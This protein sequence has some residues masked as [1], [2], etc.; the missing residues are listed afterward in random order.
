MAVLKAEILQLF[1]D[2]FAEAFPSSRN[3]L[4]LANREA[5][6]AE[7]LILPANVRL[8]CLPPYGPALNPMERVWRDLKAALAGFSSPP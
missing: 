2:A 4:L 8:V 7:R 6:T 3:R 5:Q 1:I